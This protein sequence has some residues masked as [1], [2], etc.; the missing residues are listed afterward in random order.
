[1]EL[2]DA[3]ILT[4]SLKTGELA[5]LLTGCE[6]IL[7]TLAIY[8]IRSLMMGLW[9]CRLHRRETR[10]M[11]FKADFGFGRELVGILISA[12]LALSVALVDTTLESRQVLSKDLTEKGCVHMNGHYP[13][14][15][16]EKARP[17]SYYSLD[18]TAVQITRQLDC[19]HGIRCV[20]R[21]Q[22][23]LMSESEQ[24]FA[25]KCVLPPETPA[26]N[27]QT[28]VVRTTDVG[29]GPVDQ[30]I[31]CFES[32]NTDYGRVYDDSQVL[33]IPSRT[34]PEDITFLKDFNMAA[35]TVKTILECE[36]KNI[37]ALTTRSRHE[38]TIR[39]VT[40]FA[41]A[42]MMLRRICELHP[43]V[44][45]RPSITSS[46]MKA[47]TMN[48]T[49]PCGPNDVF[50]CEQ[51]HLDHACLQENV[52]VPRNET[53]MYTAELPNM[54]VLLIN[55]NNETIDGSQSKACTNSTISYEYALVSRDSDNEKEILPIR[56][57]IRGSCEDT[58][59]VLALPAIIHSSMDG[60]SNNTYNSSFV[61]K[62]IPDENQRFHGYMFSLAR[63]YFPF[64]EKELKVQTN[65]KLRL[66]KELTIVKVN[67]QFILLIVSM[68]V[69]FVIIVVAIAL[70][71]Y[72]PS[73][74][75]KVAEVKDA[76]SH[77][78]PEYISSASI[79][80]DGLGVGTTTKIITQ[81]NNETQSW[82][83]FSEEEQGRN[84]NS[85]DG[86]SSGSSGAL[87][88]DFTNY[89][90][91]SESQQS[92]YVRVDDNSRLRRPNAASGYKIVSGP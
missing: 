88:N 85:G 24:F 30:A 49:V 2:S 37:A 16:L 44:S 92:L 70:R 23:L 61:M 7:S 86:E 15:L 68:V 74:A 38:W 28:E 91:P 60:W 83:A 66:S 4:S 58:M 5:A 75:W 73:Q 17:P 1:M 89:P 50:T 46:E 41:L 79:S 52:I 63:S 39:G 31:D 40:D 53:H 18:M 36:Q 10:Q 56:L 51:E 6:F 8:M 87:P 78:S 21:N 64:F 27:N 55:P 33:L 76:L 71:C 80:I 25:P 9:I 81:R 45:D 26:P 54:S 12:L 77:V 35:T 13:Q 42:N 72:L 62:E 67:W 57:N 34:L 47:C 20:E 90:S 11:S 3:N 32:Y 48:K 14:S 69:C 65:C 19:S 29:N 82:S 43:D 59:H 84:G 22:K